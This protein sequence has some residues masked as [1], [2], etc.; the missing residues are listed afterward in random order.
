MIVQKSVNGIFHVI[1]DD[2]AI[3]KGECLFAI[4]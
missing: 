2:D 3:T 4:S 1:S